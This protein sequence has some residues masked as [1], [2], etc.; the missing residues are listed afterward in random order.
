MVTR[1]VIQTYQRGSKGFLV[2]DQPQLAKD[3]QHCEALA[4]RLGIAGKVLVA[5]SR[6]GQPDT[7][8]WDDAVILAIHG[9]LPQ[10]VLAEAC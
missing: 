1:Y 7:G 2:P 3:K 8:E 5:F 4:E 6:S 10:E 9:D